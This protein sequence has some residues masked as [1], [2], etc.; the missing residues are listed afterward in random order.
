MSWGEEWS[1]TTPGRAPV[2]LVD[3]DA[4]LRHVAEGGGSDLHLTV[5]A[6]PTVR[7]RGEMTPVPGTAVLGAEELREALYAVMTE[8][9]R[10][11]L[12]ETR[13]L[14]FA[15]AVPGLARF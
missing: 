15:Y 1:E 10:Q 7:L 12:E 5:G 2:P 8:R 3:L 13:E 11:V 14:D 6:P 4:L 9:Q